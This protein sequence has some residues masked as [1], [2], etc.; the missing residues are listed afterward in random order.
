MAM[1]GQF[2]LGPPGS[3]KTTYCHGMQQ[4][5]LAMKRPYMVINLDPGNDQLPYDKENLID[6]K[7][8]ITVEDV[9]EEF[10]LGPNGGLVYAMEFIEDH[11]EE[12]LLAKLMEFPYWNSR[13]LIFDLPGQVELYLHHESMRNITSTL[14]KMLDLRLCCVHLVDS[15]WCRD[16]G[17]FISGTLTAL[18]CTMHLELPPVN[19]LTKVDLMKDFAKD[20]PFRL[21]YYLG[22]ED[23]SH[24]LHNAGVLRDAWMEDVN[25]SKTMEGMT[26]CADPSKAALTCQKDKESYDRLTAYLKSDEIVEHSVKQDEVEGA[27]KMKDTSSSSSTTGNKDGPPT[28]STDQIAEGEKQVVEEEKQAARGTTDAKSSAAAGV[29]G[30]SSSSSSSVDRRGTASAASTTSSTVQNERQKTSSTTKKNQFLHHPLFR[31]FKKFHESLAELVEEFNLVRFDPCN[32]EDSESVYRI[33]MRCD[34]SNGRIFAEKA[35]QEMEEQALKKTNETEMDYRRMF[36]TVLKDSTADYAEFVDRLQEKYLDSE[37]GKRERQ[38]QPSRG[39]L[40][41]N[42]VVP[43]A[44]TVGGCSMEEG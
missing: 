42:A 7:E 36:D 26:S 22:V 15:T 31:K 3:G 39:G 20:L 41:G 5:C 43:L 12:F 16:A 6:I 18:T 19:V 29:A 23:L 28:S 24:L 8:L 1:F 25:L 10:N 4:M 30:G 9:M 2:V 13:Y 38:V 35:C 44:D 40:S 32:I 37:D 27:S 34:Q 14:Q 33:L 17:S 11:I 21:D